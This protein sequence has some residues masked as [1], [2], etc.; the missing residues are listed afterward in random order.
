LILVFQAL[1][2]VAQ[3]FRENDFIKY[4]TEDGLSNNHISGILQDPGGYIW[5]STNR[6]LNRFDGNIFKQ[7][8]NKGEKDGIPDNAILSMRLLNGNELAIATGD[9]AQIISTTTLRKKNLVIPTQES[10]RYWSNSIRNV[11]AD[12]GGNYGV[13][14]KTGFYIFSPEGQLKKRYDRY[15]A[16]D[17]GVAWMTFGNYLH[18]LPDGNIVQQNNSG[19]LLYDRKNN[20]IVK[21]GDHYPAIRHRVEELIR[22]KYQFVLFAGKLVVFHEASN[23]VLMIDILTGREKS[24]PAPFNLLDEIGWQTYPSRINDSTWAVNSKNKGFFLLDINPVAEHITVHSEKYFPGQNC[25]V[26]FSDSQQ[27]LWVG[28]TDGLFMQNLHPR[29]IRSFSIAAIPP[30]HSIMSLM[31][32][33][34]RIYAGT[35]GREVLIIDKESRRIRHRIPMNSI[36]P[37]VHTVSSFHS[38]HPDSLLMSTNA[39]IYWLNTT[40]LNSGRLINE[41][42]EIFPAILFHEGEGT[43]WLGL[44]TI[45]HIIRFNLYN[46]TFD[47]ITGNTHPNLKVNRPNSFAMDKQG[48]TWIG[49]DAI[50]RWNPVKKNIDTIIEQLPGQRNR[51][52]GFHVMGD[53]GGEIWVMVNDDGYARIT[54]SSAPAHIRPENLVSRA[55]GYYYPALF[56]DRLFFPTTEGIGYLDIRTE[57]GI[58]INGADGLPATPV[59]STYFSFDSTDKST[60]FACGQTICN[61][62]YRQTDRFIRTPQ[63]NFT[64]IGVLNDTLINYPADRI[65]LG[66]LQNDIRIAISAVNFIDPQN[67]RFAYRIIQKDDDSSWIDLGTQQNILLTNISPGTYRLEAKVYAYDNKWN[68]RTKV[69]EIR[70][71][72]PFWTTPWFYAGIILLLAAAGYYFYRRRLKKLS[73]KANLDKLLAETEMKALHSQMNPHFIFNCLNSIREMILNNENRQASHYLSKFAQLIRITLNQSSKPFVS[74]ESAIDYLHRYL[75]MEQIRSTH[76]SYRMEADEGMQPADIQLPPMLIQPFIE[77]AIWH[78]NHRAN[79]VMQINIY[80]QEKNGQLVCTIEDDGMGIEA[81]LLQKSASPDHHSLGIANVKERIRVLNEKYNLQSTVSIDDKKNLPNCEG[82]GTVVTLHL[83][84]KNTFI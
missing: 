46:R 33:P 45:N 26:I 76:F 62:P 39:G 38:F 55:S 17:I 69:I 16:N 21:L 2:L 10:L 57:R 50:V 71:R 4:S 29:L 49:G 64:E 41:P 52:K 11:H 23:S 68:P 30:T 58:I 72:P 51:K 19:L 63:L 84:I 24:F 40:H 3:P 9:G 43:W 34:S 80:F 35:S 12:A 5:I 78:G 53:A 82:T 36:D 14:T 42:R 15:T 20:R 67:M 31:V 60:W 77:N 7:L 74:L 8:L 75:E 56:E 70:I 6:G 1:S 44:N 27:R 48:N 81:S 47:S 83:P 32:T 59:S 79:G 73:Q 54:G 13:S 66:H 37:E 18:L 65:S 28:T 22:A 25:T 61:I